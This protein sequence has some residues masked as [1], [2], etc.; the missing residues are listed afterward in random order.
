MSEKKESQILDVQMLGGL[1]ITCGTNSLLSDTS[2]RGKVWDLL[3]FILINRNRGYS[4]ENLI[5]LLCQDEKS[6]NPQAVI[7]NLAYR[8]RKLLDS[9]GFPAKDYILYQQGVYS[10]NPQISCTIDTELFEEKWKQA[11]NQNIT[12]EQRL[13]LYLEAIDIYR[14]RFLPK[15]A[16]KEWVLP[17]TAY[18]HRLYVECINGAYQILSQGRSLEPMVSILGRAI[19]VDPYDE[20]L[21][22]MLIETFI[23]LGRYNDAL[24]TYDRVTSLL[25]NELGIAPSQRIRALYSEITKSIQPAEK[26]I[27]EIKEDLTEPAAKPG[28]YLCD[29]EIFKTVY[30]FTARSIERTV[31]SVFLVVFTLAPKEPP[32]TNKQLKSSMQKLERVVGGSLRKGDAFARYSSTQYIVMLSGVTEESSRMVSDRILENFAKAAGTRDNATITYKLHSVNTDLE[33]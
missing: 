8:L 15:S 22:A 3:E 24:D 16:S 28:A 31:Q 30:R 2:R 17:L 12:R 13:S 14:G 23:S 27:G 32:L 10:W 25:F 7:K 26:D 9:A 19:I 21:Y 5:D 6:D 1:S 18:Y 33:L 20:N 11:E 4:S 29:Y